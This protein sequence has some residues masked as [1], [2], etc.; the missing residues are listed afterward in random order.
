MLGLNQLPLPVGLP[1]R[2]TRGGI[3]THT[4]LILNQLPLPVGL[5][6]LISTRRG[7][8]THTNLDLSQMPLP[9]WA[10][11]A[12]SWE[13]QESNL[14]MLASHAS[15]VPSGSP[16]KRSAGT[17]NRTQPRG[18]SDLEGQPDRLPASVT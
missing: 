4:L 9:N 3:R 6:A 7:I 11:R 14:L 17:E 12:Y 1:E 16:P 2:S 10:T 8:R 13:V 18:L 5:L 15:A